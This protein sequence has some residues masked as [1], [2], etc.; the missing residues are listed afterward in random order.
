MEDLSRALDEM[1]S[2]VMYVKGSLTIASDND[3]TD[4]RCLNRRNNV[5]A[6]YFHPMKSS[7][8]VPSVVRLAESGNFV[9]ENSYKKSSSSDQVG[10]MKVDLVVEILNLDYVEPI[11][12][13]TN[14]SSTSVV[15]EN[16]RELA[17]VCNFNCKNDES[18]EIVANIGQVTDVLYSFLAVLDDPGQHFWGFV[19]SYQFENITGV[20]ANILVLSREILTYLLRGFWCI[21]ASIYA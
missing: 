7:A 19:E 20:L 3:K 8:Y 13:Q 11:E 16:I 5:N 17:S 1:V 21:M 14:F 9:S 10:A 6:A 2:F 15:D 4:T 18:V 12:V